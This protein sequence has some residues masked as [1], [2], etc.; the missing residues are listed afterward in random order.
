MTR[1]SHEEQ[2][3]GCLR[4][5]ERMARRYA[6]RMPPY[7]SQWEEDFVQE[8]RIAVL[9]SWRSFDPRR[10]R[11]FSTFCANPIRFA[12]SKAQAR[13]RK[14]YGLLSLEEPH[15]VDKE[16]R[17]ADTLPASGDLECEAITAA[18]LRTALAQLKTISPRY[19]AAICA[20]Y[21]EHQRTGETA[22]G[23]GITPSTVATMRTRGL[24]R[25]REFYRAEL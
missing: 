15:G 21:L 13:I 17:V 6:H 9:I 5:A 4:M 12:L 7:F 25:L 22:Q 10:G 18:D 1:T 3:H 16:L 11:R 14:H 20:F 2:L 19:H 8:A 24:R 23:L